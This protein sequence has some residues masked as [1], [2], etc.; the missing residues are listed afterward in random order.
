[1]YEVGLSDSKRC[2][3][4]AETEY[5][6]HYMVHCSNY[7]D[8]RGE[9]LRRLPLECWTTFSWHCN[10]THF[11]FVIKPFIIKFIIVNVQGCRWLRLLCQTF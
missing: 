10:V 6:T 4:G 1:M 11:S 8:L 3:C 2:D 9:L 5:I 7:D